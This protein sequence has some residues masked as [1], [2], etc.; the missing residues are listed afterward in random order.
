VSGFSFPPVVPTTASAAEPLIVNDGWFPDVD[1]A[2]LRRERRIRE[3]VTADRLR[4][5]VLAA[6]VTVGNQLAS[7][8]DEH[9]AAGVAGLADVPAPKLDT[10]SKL[11]FL[12]RRAVG[13]YAHAE[14]VERY[15]DT[16]VTGAGQRQ[17][18]ELEPSVGELKRDGVHAIRDMLGATR[19]CVELI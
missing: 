15:R 19:T 9:R 4:A 3:A 16:D 2:R 8:A 17:V 18:D 13:A 1:L 11:L 12:Y 10:E 7:W 14:L 5:A 6:M